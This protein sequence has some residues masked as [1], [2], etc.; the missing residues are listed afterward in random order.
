VV[1]AH[2]EDRFTHDRMVDAYEAIYESV[3][4]SQQP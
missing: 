1:R 4:R 2:V 3:L